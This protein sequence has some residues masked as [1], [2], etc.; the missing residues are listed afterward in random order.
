MQNNNSDDNDSDFHNL[1]KHVIKINAPDIAQSYYS[2]DVT[3]ILI[4]IPEPYW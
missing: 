4:V 1:L 3:Y 2:L